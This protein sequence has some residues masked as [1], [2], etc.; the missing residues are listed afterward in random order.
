MVAGYVAGGR[1]RR[2]R[3]VLIPGNRV[4][5]DFRS[6]S[7]SQL[8]FARLE[9][10]E[11]RGP[12]ARRAARR[13][14]DRLGHRADRHRSARAPSLSVACCERSAGLL[15]RDLPRALGARLGAGAASTTRRCCC[16]SSAMAGAAADAPGEMPDIA[17]GDWTSSPAR[18]TDYLLADR[19]RRCYGRARSCCASELDGT[20]EGMKIAVLAGRRHRPRGHGAR[21][22]GAR[23]ARRCRGWHWSKATSA[24]PA[25]HRHGHPLPPETLEM[26]KRRRRDPVRRGRRSGVRRARTALAARAGDPRPAPGARPVRQPAPGQRCSPG[27]E[28]ASALRPEIAAR[29]D[30]LIVRE[31]NGDV[32]FGEK[33]I[34]HARPTAA[35]RAATSCP[36]PRTRCAASP[37][38]ASAPRKAA[39]RRLC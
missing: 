14:G 13:S 2:L 34:A 12:V 30:L 8:P 5:A 20:D 17:C 4:E 28:D 1:G 10:L 21:R 11:S 31:L 36:M 16:A 39:A 18:S 24:A 15:G 27:L 32:Y 35:A 3:P 26:A 6:S 38:S 19:Q 22:A 25:Y 29:I 9:L 37:T 7:D 33:A 23:C